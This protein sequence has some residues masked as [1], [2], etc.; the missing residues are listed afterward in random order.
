LPVRW[1]TAEF[2]GDWHVWATRRTAT[3]SQIR[4]GSLN[5]P[6]ENQIKFDSP[7][8]QSKSQSLAIER[9]QLEDGAN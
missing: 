6:A 4:A 9:E 5:I 8:H 7:R 3:G 1:G 2:K